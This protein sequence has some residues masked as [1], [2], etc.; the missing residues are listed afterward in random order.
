[1]LD[2]LIKISSNYYK[3]K[4]YDITASLYMLLVVYVSVVYIVYVC[5][6]LIQCSY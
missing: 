5:A 2:S 3:N 6:L 4:V 1:M